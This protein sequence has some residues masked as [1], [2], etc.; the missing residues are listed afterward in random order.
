MPWSTT[1]AH[2]DGGMAIEIFDM[3]QGSPEWYDARH[4]M[5]TMSRAA[6]ILAKGKDGPAVTRRKYLHQLAAEIVSGEPME[7]YTNRYMQRGKA[8]EAEAR[9]TY[10][11][12]RGV[13]PR[14]VGFIKD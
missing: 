9:E 7:T 5:A 12:I 2:G 13:T 8:L 3:E 11:F 1:S 6:T 4:G 14:L 10:A